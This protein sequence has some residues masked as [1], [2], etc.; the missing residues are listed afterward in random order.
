MEEDFVNP[1]DKKL[2]AADPGTLAY[3]HHAGSALVKPEEMGKVKG[4][5]MK[6]MY[7]QT[8]IQLDQIR[9]QIEHLIEQSKTIQSRVKISEQIYQAAVGFDPVI[10]HIYH[11]YSRKTDSS[12]VL[13]LVAPHEWGRKNPFEYM[14]TV[15]LMADH[16]WEILKTRV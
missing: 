4:L 15:R 14:A 2:V 10:N 1:I 3:A 13:S 16:T 6:A 9:S 12:W 8:D 5:A 7:Q 11:L